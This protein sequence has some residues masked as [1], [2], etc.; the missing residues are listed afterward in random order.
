MADKTREGLRAVVI[1]NSDGIGRALTVRLLTDG[2]TVAGLSRS[3]SDLRHPRYRHAVVD[4]ISEE[5]PDRL[6]MESDLLGGPELCVYAAG[7]GE[8]LDVSDLSAQTRTLQVN[9]IGAARTAEVVLPRMVTAGTG[10]LIGLS[11]LADATISA[12]APGYAASKAGLSA[13]FR[14]LAPALR[15]HGVAVTTVRFGFVD[16]KMAK[17]DRTPAMMSVPDAVDV[18]VRAM[19]DRPVLVSRPRRVA[20][21]VRLVVIAAT[22]RPRRLTPR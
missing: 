19:A 10:H 4:V 8:F 3:P 11:S 21:V 5:F 22:L 17:S 6:A 20:L 16:T 14:G 2:W 15:P 7:I 12:Q 18:L 9:L 13:Y 1:G